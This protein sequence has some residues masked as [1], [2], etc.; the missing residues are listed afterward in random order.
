MILLM[1]LF[2]ILGGLCFGTEIG[3]PLSDP[4]FPISAF[5]SKGTKYERG[6]TTI[7]VMEDGCRIYQGAFLAHGERATLWV[8]TF[9]V[10]GQPMQQAIVEI[11]GSCEV[12]WADDQRLQD[13]QW[14]GRLFSRFEVEV[15]A[16]VWLAADG[17]PPSTQAD[18]SEVSKTTN[19]VQPAIAW[20]AEDEAS[21]VR[22]ASQLQSA[23]MQLPPTLGTM[24]TSGNETAPPPGLP[25]RMVIGNEQMG[26]TILEGGAMPLPESR[27]EVLQPPSP[28]MPA[29][30][31]TPAP[32]VLNN[33][34]A[35]LPA[36]VALSSPDLRP[37]APRI[38]AKE[39]VFSGR[40]GVEPQ[41][42]ITPRPDRGDTVVTITRGIRLMFS[43]VAVQTS[44]GLFDMGT[45]LIEADRCIIWTSDMNRLLSRRIDDL[46]VELYLEGN[47]VFQQGNRKIYADRMYYNVQSEYGMILGAEVLT[48]AP[49]YEGIV[50][51]K[52][53]VIQQRSRENFLANGAAL[54]SSRLGVPRYWLQAD[55]IEL[56][57]Q[58]QSTSTGL[59]GFGV[60]SPQSDQTKMKAQARHNFVYLEG[61]PVLYWPILNTNVDTSS[62]YVSGFQFRQDRIFGTQAMVDWNLYQILG[63]DAVD[64]TRWNLSTDYLSERGFALGTDFRYNVPSFLNSGPAF[65]NVDAWGLND[66]GLDTLG[67]DR[68]DMIP[69]SFNR[70]R[71]IWN[72]RQLLNP[73]SELWAEVGWI[74]DR[75]FLEMYYE[76][77]WDTLK[78]RSTALR[79]RNYFKESQMLDI[80]GQARINEFFTET[81]WLP[82]LDH[83]LLGHSLGDI[84]TW[85]AHT[86][87][88]YADLQ[89]S[90]F[91]TQPQDAAKWV[92]QPWEVP[93]SGVQAV[94]RQELA[95]PFNFWYAKWTPYVSGEAAYWGED[96]NGE[97]LTRLTGQAG[98]RSATPFWQVFPDVQNTLFNINGLA[99]KVTYT[100]ETWYAGTDRDLDDLPLY[101][102]ID[103]NSQEHFRRRLIINTFGGVLPPQFESRDLAARQGLQRYVS[104]ASSQI[105]ADQMQSRIGLHQRLQTKR[106]AP[107]RERIADLVEFDVDGI[108]FYN[109]DRD[110]FGEA[111]GGINYDFRYHIGDRF[112]IVSDGYYDLFEQGLHATSIGS[113]LSRP[114]RGELYLGYTTLSGPVSSQIL[115]TTFNYRLN[116]KWAANGGTAIDFGP[117]GNTGQSF[118]ITR[119]GESFLLRLG[120]AYD[121]G[122]DNVSFQFA[123]EPR[124]FQTA[125]L[126]NV[127]GQVIPPAGL[128][129]LE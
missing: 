75:N 19:D 77:D 39:F 23:P 119:I 125:G 41:L 31:G 69:E 98:L 85:Y 122:R 84:F 51:L 96:L 126:G 73:T 68:V 18:D 14:T 49:Q 35:P 37:S 110:N 34:P 91:P 104:A 74:S 63:I 114:G 117:T 33:G 28:S 86:N 54:T 42:Q 15:N 32:M 13:A 124:F 107:G 4:K 118:G 116:E 67:S 121:Q 17:V 113:I 76:S 24:S 59:M 78:D 16:G 6:D 120:V 5:A 103:D 82:R 30:P 90:S 112:A 8:K 40:G 64:G 93:S 7:Y 27:V 129:G 101:D 3:V 115:N 56:N 48:P 92:Y 123:L 60:L 87:V 57:D 111:V 71:V 99:H 88:G 81:Q 12:R 44:G 108:F 1:F 72:H 50:R 10:D 36:P 29:T 109:P 105:V 100:S 128:Y 45:V 20:T 70:G 62:F 2:T 38:G 22:L 94:T 11:D 80:W 83:Y 97:S 52:A 9:E 55:R 53:D 89:I 65:G 43:D 26:G 46:P 95:L 61:V 58:R 102:P 106:G 25:N 79:Y 66:S 47:I 21:Y 127:G